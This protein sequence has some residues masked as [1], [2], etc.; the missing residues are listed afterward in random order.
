VGGWGQN[1]TVQCPLYLISDKHRFFGLCCAMFVSC[2][3]HARAMFVPCSCHAHVM[4]I[5]CSLTF[6]LEYSALH[7][8]QVSNGIAFVRLEKCSL[9][10]SDQSHV[11]EHY[12]KW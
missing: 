3:C 4:F 5:Q 8:I 10:T 6:G 9:G 2:S 7:E 12:H 11:T 1:N